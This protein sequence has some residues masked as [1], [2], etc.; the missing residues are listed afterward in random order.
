M[1]KRRARRIEQLIEVVTGRLVARDGATP[2]DETR[3]VWRRSSSSIRVED[4]LAA[5]AKE[6]D[7]VLDLLVQLVPRSHPN[8]V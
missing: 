5:E 3:V 1:G 6:V 2:V 8:S 7:M 4:A